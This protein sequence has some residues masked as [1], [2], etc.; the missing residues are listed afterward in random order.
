[1]DQ[2]LRHGATSYPVRT[3]HASVIA[4]PDA[5]LRVTGD[6]LAIGTAE[7]STLRLADPSVSRFHVTLQAAA[8]GV[9][10]VDHGSTNGTFA[11]GVRIERAVIHQAA[12]S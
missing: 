11:G 10:V 6:A 2:T 12:R 3:I 1:M 8:N 5:G 7:G 4:G 9:H